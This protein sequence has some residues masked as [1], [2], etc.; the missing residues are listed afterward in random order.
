MVVVLVII[1]NSS[2]GVV[3]TANTTSMVKGA[4][5][6]VIASS[7]PNLISRLLPT[8]LYKLGAVFATVVVLL[9]IAV[10]GVYLYYALQPKAQEETT[11][12][13]ESAV[14]TEDEPQSTNFI[15]YLATA[16]VTIVV[17]IVIVLVFVKTHS[18]KDDSH[19]R[20][21]SFNANRRVKEVT[22][23]FDNFDA[24]IVFIQAGHPPTAKIGKY[25][26]AFMAGS[27]REAVS[28]YIGDRVKADPTISPITH[29]ASD[30][31]V[32]YA[33][34][35]PYNNLKICNVHLAGIK[36][37]D[38]R[39]LTNSD[40]YLN[41]KMDLLK[42]VVE[43]GADI[44]F[45]EFFSLYS[46]NQDRRDKSLKSL[47]ECMYRM[48]QKVKWTNDIRDKIKM[49]NL[50]PIE[51]LMEQGYSYVPVENEEKLSSASFGMNSHVLTKLSPEKYNISVSLMRM[52]DYTH[53]YD[54]LLVEIDKK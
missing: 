17:L 26:F 4:A 43:F 28:M 10:A 12:S 15:S 13:A 5:K 14:T 6:Q 1:M 42:K 54:A 49:C 33:V 2:D 24:D 19:F 45:G 27:G 38:D 11:K 46:H 36:V 37:T 35:I 34:C 40:H 25:D 41:M 47:T 9:V 3:T 20:L 21:V 39:W 50:R 22:N 16:V 31:L 53:A 18:N 52:D 30:N 48:Y 7:Q 29:Q 32:T 51:W 8:R 44:I 23:E